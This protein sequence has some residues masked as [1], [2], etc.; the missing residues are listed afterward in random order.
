M[1]AYVMLRCE[2]KSMH[3]RSPSCTLLDDCLHL[4]PLPDGYVALGFRSDGHESRFSLS[5]TLGFCRQ[6]R[7]TTGDDGERP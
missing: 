3:S 2:D 1:F 6:L 4:V 5:D 7:M